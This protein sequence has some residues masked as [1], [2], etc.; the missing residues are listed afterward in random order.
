MQ[1]VYDELTAAFRRN[2][3]YLSAPSY[4]RIVKKYTTLFEDADVLF[5]LLQAS[6]YPI[7]EEGD[8]YVLESYFTPYEEQKYCVID[9]ETNG[10]KPETAQVIEVGAVMVQNGEIIDRFESFVEC[11]FLPEYISKIT[12]IVPEDLADA[13]SRLD[14]LSKLRVFMDN[15]I[16]V[17]H[18]ANFDYGFLNH[19]FDRFGLGS[20]GNQKLCSIDLAR[21]TIESKRYGL[22]YLNESLELGDHMHHRAFSDAL[23]TT[24]LFALTFKNIPDYVQTT[25]EL[26]RFSTSSRK[27]RTNQKNSSLV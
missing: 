16:F 24:K 25:D 19:S 8:R 9:I 4:Q 6:G 14:V 22:A 1:K 11:A 17:A 26:L 21:R 23:I 27:D 18:N 12:G 5:L 13:P 7:K 15:A 10:S 3:G 2:E 20:I